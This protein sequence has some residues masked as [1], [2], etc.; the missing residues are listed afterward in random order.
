MPESVVALL[1]NILHVTYLQIL[2]KIVEHP[3]SLWILTVLY[4]NQRTNL[5]R[6]HESCEDWVFEI[7]TRNEARLKS[8]MIVANTNFQLLLAHD[9]FLRPIGVV[10]PRGW[11]VRERVK[12][13]LLTPPYFVISLDS[14]ILLSSFTTNGPTHTT[15]KEQMG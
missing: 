14:T 12:S 2:D 3:E 6:L 1:K 4:V 13:Q 15:L 7:F 8:N 9:V 10:F 5:C 11:A